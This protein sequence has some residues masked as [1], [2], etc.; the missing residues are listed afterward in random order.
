VSTRISRSLIPAAR[1]L[2]VVG[3]ACGCAGTARTPRRARGG[4]AEFADRVRAGA[5]QLDQVRLLPRAELRLLAAQSALGSGYRHPFAC[6]STS[7]I[8]FKFRGHGQRGEQEPADR[9]GRVVHRSA[10][11]QPDA[12][13]GQLVDD[14]TRVGDGAGHRSSL[15]TTR[16]SPRR[17]AARASRRPGRARLVPVSPWST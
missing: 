10:D 11:V 5:I 12:A 4:G 1:A 14:V 6:S 13:G 7:K 3:P 16:V 2:G 8:R 9:V 17:Q 15:V